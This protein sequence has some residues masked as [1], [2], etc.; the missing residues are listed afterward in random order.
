M[1]LLHFCDTF[2]ALLREKSEGAFDIMLTRLIHDP[3]Y[4]KKERNIP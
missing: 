2:S 4:F 3:K 1:A